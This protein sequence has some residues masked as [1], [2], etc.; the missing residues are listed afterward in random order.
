MV[1]IAA[2]IESQAY[3]ASDELFVVFDAMER[4]LA[5]QVYSLNT[6]YD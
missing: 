2:A 4:I 6:I 1:I 5:R 3:L